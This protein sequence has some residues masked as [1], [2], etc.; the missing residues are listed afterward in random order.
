MI[1]DIGGW[2]YDPESERMFVIKSSSGYGVCLS[3][4]RD[5]NTEGADSYY[6]DSHIVYLINEHFMYYI[7][8]TEDYDTFM[9]QIFAINL[10][11][12]YS[13]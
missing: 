13:E 11:H 5:N 1:Y 7:P 4:C 6:S 10:K 2:L 12:D 3:E 9:K 8:H